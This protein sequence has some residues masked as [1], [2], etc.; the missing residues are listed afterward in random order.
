ML[1][2]YSVLYVIHGSQSVDPFPARVE[3]DFLV[4]LISI[5][6]TTN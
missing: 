3:H 4:L 2:V 5:R 6:E 1:V